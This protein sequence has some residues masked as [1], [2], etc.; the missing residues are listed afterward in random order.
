MASRIMTSIYGRALQFC[1]SAKARRFDT[2]ASRVRAI[3]VK[4]EMGDR[5]C[6]MAVGIVI[7]VSMRRR[8]R[9]RSRRRRRRDVTAASRVTAIVVKR[10]MGRI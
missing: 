7:L 8:R 5:N 9:R 3:V 2:S 1:N 4:L 6:E 10:E